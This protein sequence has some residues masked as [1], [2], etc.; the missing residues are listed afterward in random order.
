MSDSISCPRC[1]WA[2][3]TGGSFC[4][5]CATRLNVASQSSAMPQPRSSLL[6][7]Q[8]SGPSPGYPSAAAME[9]SVERRANIDQTKTGLLLAIIGII[10]SA[11]PFVPYVGSILIIIGIVLIWVGRDAFG[12]RHSS[13]CQSCDCIDISRIYHRLHGIF[14]GLVRARSSVAQ[15]HRSDTCSPIRDLNFR[16]AS[17]RHRCQRYCHRRSLRTSNVRIAGTVWAT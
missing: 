1:G 9:R 12:E 16:M 10:L 8:P 3:P 14:S 4:S 5:K 13:F 17:C 2:N 15:F 6:S 7:T 11:V